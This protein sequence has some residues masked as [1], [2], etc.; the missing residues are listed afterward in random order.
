MLTAGESLWWDHDRLTF[1]SALLFLKLY[2]KS[3]V[4]IP[5]KAGILNLSLVSAKINYLWILTLNAQKGSGSM[6]ISASVFITEWHTVGEKVF[7]SGTK[8]IVTGR[9]NT[10]LNCL[11]C[12]FF[13]IL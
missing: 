6:K 11:N 10:F 13:L 3:T 4:N 12:V 7:G 1:I 8:L 9:K 5:S 2:V